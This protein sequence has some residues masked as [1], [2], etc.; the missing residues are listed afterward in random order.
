MTADLLSRLQSALEGHYIV[1][2]ELGRGGMATVYLAHDLRHD[3]PVALKVLHSELAQSVGPDRFAREIRFA[4]RLQHP[5]VLSVHDSGDTGAGQLWFTMPYVDGESLRDRLRREGQ[6]SLDEALRIAREAAQALQYAH[7]QGV[8]H[9]DI[10]PENLLLSKDGSTLVA[11]FGVARALGASEALTQTGMAVGTPAYMSPEQATG[12]GAI[13]ARSDVY[14]L[15][16]VLYEM[17]AGEPPFTGPNA[18]A[19]I[20]KRFSTT[21]TPVRVVRPDVPEAVEA[22]VARA[23]ARSPAG[24]FASAAELGRALQPAVMTPGGTR[25]AALPIPRGLGLSR[26]A[27]ALLGGGAVLAVVSLVAFLVRPGAVRRTLSV[28]QLTYTGTASMP[29]LSPDGRSVAYLS[30]SR[31]LMVQGLD[32][33]DPVVLVPPAR[34]AGW[35]R[36]S[37]D[38]HTIVFIMFTDSLGLAATYAVPSAGGAARKVLEDQLPLDPGPDSTFLVRIPRERHRIEVIDWTT[39]RTVRTTP[40]PAEVDDGFA[41]ATW[42]PDRHWFTVEAFGAIWT[43]PSAGGAPSKLMPGTNP[44]WAPGSDAV[45]VLGGTPGSEALFKA[46]L[47]PRTGSLRGGITRLASLPG[48]KGFDVRNGRLVYALAATSQQARV[49]ALEGRPGLIAADRVV[50][51]GTAPVTNVTISADGRTVAFSQARSGDENVYILPFDSGSPR[52]IAASPAA[53]FAPALAPDGSRIAYVREDSLGR[54]LM[55]ADLSGGT[56]RRVG[57]LPFSGTGNVLGSPNR[58]RWS[59]DGLYLAYPARDQRRLALIDL[60]RGTERDL[61]IADSIGAGYGEVVP[62][63]D[64]RTLVASTLRRW[65]DWG[66]VW[67]S[68]ADAG[69]WRRARAPFGENYPLAW[70]ADGWIYLEN[71]RAMSTDHGAVRVELWRTRGPDGVPELVAPLPEGCMQADVAADGRRVVCV[72]LRTESDLYLGT[73]FDPDVMHP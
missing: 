23:L 60:A 57:S 42:S 28:R 65:T 46:S 15:G 21:P 11:D 68:A 7:E 48:A 30:G 4:A 47:D 51:Q 33:G 66:E 72:S 31:A 6:L 29:A 49:L 26:R 10:K 25:T 71:H 55:V 24:R 52:P 34:F 63:P 16:C 20:A 2:R 1:E 53:E 62:A 3:R 19:I 5:H 17:L 50:S 67:T 22:A 36:W 70:A 9:R 13:D 39:G 43:M 38:G 58:P 27:A 35:P 61:A 44:R 40:L 56:V 73:D 8:I 14:A 59:A 41:A 45:Y 69:T 32:G 54:A 64:G 18:Q 12:E 37:A